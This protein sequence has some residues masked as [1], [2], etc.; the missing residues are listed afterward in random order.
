MSLDDAPESETEPA[1]NIKAS[2]VP[3]PASEE[4]NIHVHNDHGTGGGI[5][6]KLVFFIFLSI[7]AVLIG[8]ILVEKRGLT[9]CK[10][11]KSITHTDKSKPLNLFL[12]LQKD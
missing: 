5:C 9:D 1:V 4:F 12:M 8:L 11:Y 10:Y 3:S 2:N 6:A 7:I